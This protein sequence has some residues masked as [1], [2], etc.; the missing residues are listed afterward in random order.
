MRTSRTAVFAATAVIAIAGLPGL[1][2]AEIKDAHV[3]ALRLPDGS[4]ERIRYVGDSAPQVSVT[5]APAFAAVSPA[6]GPF[7]PAS[8]FADLQRISAALDRQAAAMLRETN[9]W[10]EPALYGPDGGMQIDVDKLPPGVQGYSV[11]STTSG[12]GVCTRSIQYTSSGDGRPPR[13][14]TRTSGQCGAGRTRNTHDPHLLQTVGKH[15][16]APL[17]PDRGLIHTVAAPGR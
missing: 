13:V 9:R 10:S 12:D 15:G 16:D 8:P 5:S 14:L 2:A 7:G 6:A 3:L 11:V 4:I 1:A 17:G